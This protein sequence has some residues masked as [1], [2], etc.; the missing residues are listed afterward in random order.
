MRILGLDPGSKSVKAIEL[1]SAFGRL[2]VHE[3]HEEPIASHEETAEAAIRR[4]FAKLARQPDKVACALPTGKATFRNLRIPTRDKK[5]IQQ[6]VAFELEDELPFELSESK[7]ETSILR[8]EGNQ[9]EVHVAA[10]LDETLQSSIDLLNRAGVDPDLITTESW[11]LRTLLNKILPT[12]HQD[13]PIVVLHVGHERSVFYAHWTGMPILVKEYQFGSSHLASVLAERHQ[14]ST[15]DAETILT[16]EAYI[17]PP[18]LYE[19]STPEQ[20]EFSDL[21][22]QPLAGVLITLKQFLLACRSSTQIYPKR[23]FISGGTSQLQGFAALIEEELAVPVSPLQSLTALNLGAVQYS[24]QTDS[25]FTVAAGLALTWVGSEK[26]VAINFRKGE[27]AK[28]GGA[29]ELPLARFKRPLISLGVVLLCFLISLWVESGIYE[30]K[31]AD[32]EQQVE[33]GIKSFF[34]QLSASGVRNYISRP[35]ELKKA[36]NRELSEQ[37]ELNR[38]LGKNPYSPLLALRD[39]SIAIPKE[40]VVDVIQFKVGSAP[41]SPYDPKVEPDTAITLLV[42]NPQMAEQ[43]AQSLPSRINQMTKSP[44]EEV[45]ATEGSPKRWKV[46]FSGKGR[47][48][49]GTQAE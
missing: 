46:T 23:I 27:F 28:K 10:T 41:T 38:L 16:Q 44:L 42:S 35:S 24:G 17:L 8:Q 15:T 34:G 37:R 7:W 11:A 6:T 18:S 32:S 45:Q 20:K 36:V 4:I 49:I 39:I 14:I 48:A 25:C 43:V 33:R 21:L 47:P 5:A 29:S 1:D 9:T 2:E 12:A 19:K 22:L 26:S 3:F 30:R 40:T 13:S 31:L